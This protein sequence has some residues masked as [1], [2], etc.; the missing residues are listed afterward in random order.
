MSEFKAVK[1]RYSQNIGEAYYDYSTYVQSMVS[2]M[3]K[4][5]SFCF[6]SPRAPS[7][8]DAIWICGFALRHFPAHR[9]SFTS[10][11]CQV[12]LEHC[13]SP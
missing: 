8:R 3:L 7:S 1:F 13:Y 9:V 4:C 12:E 11:N 2:L 6:E 5:Y 10:F